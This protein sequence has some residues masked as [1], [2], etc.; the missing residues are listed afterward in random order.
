MIQITELTRRYGD[1]VA[2][3]SVTLTIP[4]GKVF[5]LLGPNGAGKSTT[6]KCI[7]G[8]MRP[9]SGRILVDGI[10]VVEKPMDVKRLIGYVPEN[11]SLFK[12]LSGK[13]LLTLVG[14]LHHL[15][16]ELL[17]KRID[18]LLAPLGLTSKADEHIQTYS[19]GMTQKLAIAAALIHNPRVLVLDEGLNGLD[20]SAAAILKRLIRAFADSGKTVVF[21]SHILEVVERLCDEIAIIAQGRLRVIG[22]V[23]RILADTGAPSLEQAFI[24]L[25]G[26]TDVAREASDILSAL[27]GEAEQ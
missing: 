23:K 19:K 14:R 2:V 24:G 7:T 15:D 12:S 6:V 3:D 1:L 11:P 10:D 13:E 22:P 20:A 18:E 27:S 5:G 4:E 21:C 26:E 16:G 8:V 9:T 25:T 17:S